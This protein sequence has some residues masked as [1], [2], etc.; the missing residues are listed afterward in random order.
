[1]G[2]SSQSRC[3]CMGRH[4]DLD[5]TLGVSSWLVSK[6]KTKLSWARSWRVESHGHEQGAHHC[7]CGRAC[8]DPDLVCA[9]DLDTH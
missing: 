6:R 8:V 7:S 9:A 3:D 1:M 4:H 5:L 2:L